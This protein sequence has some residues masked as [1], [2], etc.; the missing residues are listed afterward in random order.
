ME[1]DTVPL[2]NV[3]D[4]L[5]LTIKV[6]RSHVLFVLYLNFY[7]LMILS[8]KVFDPQKTS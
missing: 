2:S 1:I 7:N 3:L 6:C 8:N 4:Q 5:G